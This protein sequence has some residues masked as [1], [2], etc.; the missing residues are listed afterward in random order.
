VG[1]YFAVVFIEF[2]SQGS[3]PGLLE[4]LGGVSEVR[5]GTKAGHDEE[6]QGE[7]LL[8]VGEVMALHTGRLRKTGKVVCIGYVELFYLNIRQLLL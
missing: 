6:E 2:G 7:D 3:L 1:L 5:K 4:F 8:S